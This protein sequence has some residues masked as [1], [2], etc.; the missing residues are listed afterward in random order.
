METHSHDLPD[1]PENRCSMPD[2][3]GCANFTTGWDAALLRLKV[4]FDDEEYL[5]DCQHKVETRWCEPCS[6][7][8]TIIRFSRS[9][10]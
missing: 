5:P 3:T 10:S 4:V 8:H 2:C 6:I 1:S 9:G 7:I